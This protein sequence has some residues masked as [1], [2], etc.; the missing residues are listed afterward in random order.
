MLY[1]KKDTLNVPALG[2]GTWQ[3]NGDQCVEAI[4]AGLE[5]GYR[6]IDTAQIYENEEY[7]GAGLSKSAV[8]R[9]DIFLTTK[10]WRDNI[11][12]QSFASSL[13][14]SLRK[15]KTDYVDMLL[16]HWPFEEIDDSTW[17]QLVQA[18]EKGQTRAIGISNFTVAQMQ[19]VVEQRGIPVVNNQV[20]YHPKLSQ[21]PVLEYARAH[22]MFLTAYSPLGRGDVFQE[23]VLKD[24]A[25]KYNK[26]EGQISLRWLIQQQ[27]VAAIPKSSNPKHLK[28]NFDIFDF[29]L[30][31]S[32]MRDVF[33]LAS[34]QGRKISPTW[35]DQDWDTAKAA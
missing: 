3:A 33:N 21:A 4:K 8:N 13:E 1:I 35:L 10:I 16:I 23:P 27:D 28:A 6:H 22:D 25:S 24:L 15:L 17:D 7:V 32:E 34:P 11:T 30:T 20:E 9:A 12:G 14:E 31:E 29:E 5:I 2:L 19:D 18:K 26:N